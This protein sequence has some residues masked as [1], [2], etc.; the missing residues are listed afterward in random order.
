[1]GIRSNCS[2]KV[3]MSNAV[4]GGAGGKRKAKDE[5]LNSG[6][7]SR[8][9]VDLQA[10]VWESLSELCTEMISLDANPVRF[11]TKNSGGAIDIS[12]SM[13]E[14]RDYDWFD[15]DTSGNIVLQP[16]IPI[17]PED[18]PPGKKE[19]P[20]SWWGIVDPVLGERKD[21]KVVYSSGITGDAPPPPKE[22]AANKESEFK[23]KRCC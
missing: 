19:W 23:K 4:V 17:F 8:P 22:A 14:S 5:L 2:V 1:M 21:R 15:L 16:K 3:V 7:K 11:E 9:N 18:F 6:G 10:R 12:G 20:L 13:M